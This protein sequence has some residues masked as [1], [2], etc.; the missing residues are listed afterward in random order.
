MRQQGIC[1]DKDI[2]FILGREYGFLFLFA[3]RW[4]LRNVAYLS[5]RS[6]GLI[7]ANWYELTVQIFSFV[8]AEDFF[9]L[10]VW[11]CVTLR[12]SRLLNDTVLSCSLMRSRRPQRMSQLNPLKQPLGRGWVGWIQPPWPHINLCPS[13]R[14]SMHLG[15][16]Q[17]ACVCVSVCVWI[18]RLGVAPSNPIALLVENHPH[19]PHMNDLPLICGLLSFGIIAQNGMG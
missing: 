5:E 11:W 15:V 19:K 7:R 16:S 9:S 18:K 17:S 14:F 12:L 13:P 10:V 8:I 1:C 4:I 6:L 3:R 2:L